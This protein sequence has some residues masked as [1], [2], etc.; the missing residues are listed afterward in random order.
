MAIGLRASLP[1]PALLTLNTSTRKLEY[2]PVNSQGGK[3]SVPFSAPLSGDPSFVAGAFDDTVILASQHPPAILL[4]NLRT[5]ALRQVPD[6]YGVPADVAVDK[7]H[8][9]YVLNADAGAGSV[10]EYAAATLRP[11]VLTCSKIGM[12]EA[13]AVDNEGDV[14]VN[15]Y[16]PHAAPGVIEILGT[17][18]G[19][20]P[21]PCVRLALR[22]ETGYVAGVA[23][24]PKND[25]LIVFD[26]PDFCAG[27]IEGRMT[28]YAK[29]YGA[30]PT[31]RNLDGVC[32]GGIRLDATST[33]IFFN[34]QTVSGS[35][36]YIVQTTYPGGTGNA[37]YE[38][39]RPGGLAPYPSA[40]PN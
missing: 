12:G 33:R 34:D 19:P 31:V 9:L 27:G 3:R 16:V 8:D 1:R 39:G 38:G 14:F 17:T 28:I 23:V 4:Y 18:A 21:R 13:I 24:D 5:M 6:T 25:D 20:G 37:V 11:Q 35:R 30:T 2:W 40:L 32:P 15:G 7:Q 36:A 29:P 26:D 22:P 10:V